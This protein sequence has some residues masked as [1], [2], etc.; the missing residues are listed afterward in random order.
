MRPALQRSDA[1]AHRR[2]ATVASILILLLL[3]LTVPFP[4]GAHAATSPSPSTPAARSTVVTRSAHIGYL[5]CPV[6]HVLLTASI[7]RRSFTVGQP[8]TYKVAVRNLSHTTCGTPGRPLP[9]IPT[10]PTVAL[11][12]LGPCGELSVVIYDAAGTDVYPGPV[13]Y[14]CP[15]IVGPAL[16]PGQSLATTGTWT[17]APVRASGRYRL[18]IAGK[19]TLPIVLAEATAAPT[20]TPL[21]GSGALPLPKTKVPPPSVLPTPTTPPPPPSLAP[22]VGGSVSLPAHGTLT[23]NEHWIVGYTDLAPDPAGGSQSHPGPP[24]WWSGRAGPGR[25]VHR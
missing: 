23:A 3:G 18:V 6:P 21:P 15:M 12:L 2:A 24:G 7:A 13:A 20:P 17:P 10:A 14:G 8:V 1:L 25:T 5:N 16:H 22:P 9:T 19:V 11:G 4:A